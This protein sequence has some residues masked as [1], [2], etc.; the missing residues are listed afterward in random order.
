[1]KTS[2]LNTAL[3]AAGVLAVGTAGAFTLRPDLR[4]SDGT[5]LTADDVRRS[6]L[7]VIDPRAPSPLASLLYDVEGARDY[8]TRRGMVYML[9]RTDVPVEDVVTKYLRQRGLVR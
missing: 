9:A 8:C 2:S 4:F 3:I 1:M 7:R 6:W 5:T